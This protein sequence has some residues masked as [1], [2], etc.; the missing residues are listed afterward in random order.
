VLDR[1]VREVP[2]LVTGVERTVAES[3]RKALQ[4]PADG[5][6]PA[7]TEWPP[8]TPAEWDRVYGLGVVLT[9]R[10]DQRSTI[11]KGVGRSRTA[12]P[13]WWRELRAAARRADAATLDG[14]VAL[15]AAAVLQGRAAAAQSQAARGVSERRTGQIRSWRLLGAGVAVAIVA[16]ALMAWA[17]A[18]GRFVVEAGTTDIAGIGKAVGSSAARSQYQLLPVIVL[19]A[20]EAAALSRFAGEVLYGACLGSAVLG[21]L[22]TKLPEFPMVRLPAS[23]AAPLVRLGG[24]WD[25]ITWPAAIGFAVVGLVLAGQAVRLVRLG[26]GGTAAANRAGRATPPLR[27]VLRLGAAPVLLLVLLAVLWVAVTM[28]VSTTVGIP[29]AGA[30]RIGLRAAQF[31]SAYLPVFAFLALLA[32]LRRPGRGHE[33]FVM[34]VLAATAIGLWTRPVPAPVAALRWPVAREQLTWIAT[35][36]GDGVLWATVLLYLPA[37]VVG[38]RLGYDRLRA[39]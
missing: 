12:A 35:Q 10:P 1:V 25:R 29:A 4:R 2:E 15:V 3:G 11:L 31:Q 17:G 19:L 22:A 18:V 14:R 27:G 23:G 5:G 20:L 26:A 39:A 34:A 37:A 32:C 7:A 9:L 13:P 16:M 21:Y 36:W 30:V 33:V 6:A 24:S 38:A 28:R 8:L